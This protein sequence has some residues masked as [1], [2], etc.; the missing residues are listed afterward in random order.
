[1][2]DAPAA[3]E[4]KVRVATL[5]RADARVRLI[6]EGILV[7]DDHAVEVIGEDA[8]GDQAGFP[9]AEHDRSALTADAGCSSGVHPK[10]PS[11][12]FFSGRPVSR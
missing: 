12:W 1:L 4:Q 2:E 9:G 3:V 5:G 11:V 6:G 7:H 10:L 8:R